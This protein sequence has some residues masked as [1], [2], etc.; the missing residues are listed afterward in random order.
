MCQVC[1]AV[2][3]RQ[4]RLHPLHLPISVCRKERKM[5]KASNLHLLLRSKRVIDS[6]MLYGLLRLRERLR[7]MREQMRCCKYPLHVHANTCADLS[8]HC[9]HVPKAKSARRT[10]RASSH[11]PVVRFQAGKGPIVSVHTGK[12]RTALAL[13]YRRTPASRMNFITN[14]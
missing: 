6:W 9:R 13:V 7:T 3:P 12:S 1:M 2:H 10:V 11:A 4:E 8:T 5:R 14:M